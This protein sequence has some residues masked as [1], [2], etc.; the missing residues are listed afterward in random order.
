[1]PFAVGMSR[2]RKGERKKCAV[3]SAQ[4][5]GKAGSG[6]RFRIEAVG[7]IAARSCV[8]FPSPPGARSNGAR[9]AVPLRITMPRF[10]FG[11]RTSDR[12]HQTAFF[13]RLPSSVSRLRFSRLRFFLHSPLLLNPLRYLMA[14]RPALAPSPTATLICRKLPTQSPAAN[15]PGTLVFWSLSASM[16]TPLRRSPRE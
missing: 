9:R 14:E 13:S 6:W 7:G 4:G 10:D 15:T 8:C 1:M 5:A 12:R 11:P 3:R 2:N 16:N